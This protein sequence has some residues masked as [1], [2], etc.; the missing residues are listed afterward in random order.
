MAA[1][2]DMSVDPDDSSASHESYIMEV[3]TE[4]DEGSEV[5]IRA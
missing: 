5:C 3:I 2:D 1:E 4:E